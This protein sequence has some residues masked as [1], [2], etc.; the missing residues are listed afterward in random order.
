MEI[1]PHA[2]SLYISWDPPLDSNSA[3]T[4]YILRHRRLRLGD[5]V[6]RADT[7]NPLIDVAP[8]QTHHELTGLEPYS[9]YSVKIWVRT[10]KHKKG[11]TV[12][13]NAT[14]SAAGKIDVTDA[15]FA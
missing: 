8:N 3:I 15:L 9:L 13:V 7:K 1:T 10:V 12:T 11:Q 14:T 2:T 4:N 5:C 6:A